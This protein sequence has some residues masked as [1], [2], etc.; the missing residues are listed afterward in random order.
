MKRDGLNKHTL[1][2]KCGVPYTTIVGLY[3][4][5]PENA[6][7]S[8]INRLCDFFNVSLDYLAFDE[9]EKPED[10]KPGANTSS[11]TLTDEES[12]LLTGFRSLNRAGKDFILSALNSTLC[13]PQMKEGL[14]QNREIS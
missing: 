8:T 3:E 12:E 10:F 13:N 14:I 1:A 4:R 6:R 2:Q 5:G 7:L 9:Y 11:I